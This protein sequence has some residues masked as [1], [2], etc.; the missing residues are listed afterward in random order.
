MTLGLLQQR[1]ST[2]AAQQQQATAEL[3]CSSSRFDALSPWFRW[4]GRRRNY[5]SGCGPFLPRC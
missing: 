4:K 1:V 5:M 3:H 2:D